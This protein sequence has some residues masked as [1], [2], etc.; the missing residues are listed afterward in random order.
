[1]ASLNYLYLKVTR[2]SACKRLL[3]S[4]QAERGRKLMR[5]K[6]RK[7]SNYKSHA[8]GADTIFRVGTRPLAYIYHSRAKI[9]VK[10]HE[11]VV[12]HKS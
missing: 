5:K 2:C 8:P 7:R 9:G 12:K 1:M 6:A 4:L 3:G 10:F 11:L